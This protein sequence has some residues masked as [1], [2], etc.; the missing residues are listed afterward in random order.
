MPKIKIKIEKN[1]PIPKGIGRR[2]KDYPFAD[3]VK[4]D[5][6]LIKVQQR[7]KRKFK[8]RNLTQSAVNFC[9]INNK[10]WKFSYRIT[11]DGVRIWRIK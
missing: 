8:A 7:T 2:V 1:I 9:R 10:N 4:G 5:S 6:F 11:D 3:M